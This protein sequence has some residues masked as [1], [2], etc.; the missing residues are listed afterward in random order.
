MAKLALVFAGQG[1]Q[2]LGMGTDYLDHFPD[3]EHIADQ[4]LG[5]HVRDILND[6]EGKI[7]QTEFTQPLVFLSSALGYEAFKRLGVLPEGLLGFSLGEYTA[8]YASGIYGFQDAL[9]LIQF[10]AYA[11]M[12]SASETEGGMAA[13]LG[14]KRDE[15]EQVCKEAS[16]TAPV[17]AVNFNSPI[18][19]VISGS[20]EGVLLA[21]D[22]CKQKGA[23]R[24]IPLQVSGAFH[25]PLMAKAGEALENHLKNYDFRPAKLPIYMNVNAQPLKDDELK[26]LMVKQIQSPVEFENSILKMKEDGFTHFLEIGPGSVLTGLI[27]KIDN[28]LEVFHLDH[29]SELEDVKGWLNTHGFNQ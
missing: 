2:Y 20:K 11:M 17:W 19:T 10:R 1:S 6:A 3:K 8:L 22:L 26:S 9:A 25:S 24:A 27:K 16:M 21:V 4:Q 13:I 12:Q 7:H 28:S 14:L 23:K 29:L 5:Y 15:V 18:Q